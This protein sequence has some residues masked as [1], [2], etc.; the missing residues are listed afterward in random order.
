MN[1]K[2]AKKQ[3][4][5]YN[6]GFVFFFSCFT[7]D[8]GNI[9]FH[10][11]LLS[12]SSVQ[13]SHSGTFTVIIVAQGGKK[14]MKMNS[15]CLVFLWLHLIVSSVKSEYV[16]KNDNVPSMN[17]ILQ[18]VRINAAK[19]IIETIIISLLVRQNDDEMKKKK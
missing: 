8:K 10:F 14:K 6:N 16:K 1:R 3:I 18:I 15:W 13:C 9:S 4:T 5:R 19:S 12:P 17:T 2:R 11:F 7:R